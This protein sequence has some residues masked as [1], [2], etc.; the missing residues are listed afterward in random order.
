MVLFHQPLGLTPIN[1]F[2]VYPGLF[3]SEESIKVKDINNTPLVISIHWGNRG[4]VVNPYL[5]IY[6]RILANNNQ[7]HIIIEVADATH[8][9][10]AFTTGLYNF[11]LILFGQ[12]DE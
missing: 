1:H 9:V 6:H 8:D 2:K 12:L 4:D 11:V 10:K 5:A 3:P 7:P